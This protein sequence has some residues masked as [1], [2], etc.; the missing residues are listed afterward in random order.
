MTPSVQLWIYH[1]KSEMKRVCKQAFAFLNWICRS[2]RER[3][4]LGW[5][6]EED[7]VMRTLDGKMPINLRGEWQSSKVRKNQNGSP[8]CG[9][10]GQFW[11]FSKFYSGTARLKRSVKV[12]F[13]AHGHTHTHTQSLWENVSWQKFTPWWNWENKKKRPGLFGEGP[14][15][16][17]TWGNF[18]L[19]T[20][21]LVLFL[22]LPLVWGIS[23][24]YG[25]YK[26]LCSKIT[27]LGVPPNSD[28][29]QTPA[30][31]CSKGKIKWMF[32][33]RCA[34]I[35]LATTSFNLHCRC[36]IKKGSNPRIE[37]R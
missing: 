1:H 37:S 18:S 29:W 36:T 27:L 7:R 6:G 19:E 17:P 28:K 26:G 32:R 31:F 25:N 11:I 16:W 2:Y 13:T 12:V 9:L 33:P 22:F 34:D 23:G 14:V 4:S 5:G 8:V 20:L 35:N 21:L 24:N 30:V 3:E 15:Y 10:S